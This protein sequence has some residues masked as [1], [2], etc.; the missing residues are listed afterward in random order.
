[1]QPS[2][3]PIATSLNLP[4]HQKCTACSLAKWRK[5]VAPGRGRSDSPLMFVAEAPGAEEDEEGAPLIGPAGRLLRSLVDAMPSMRAD[6][7]FYTN[8]AHCRPPQNDVRYFEETGGLCPK[9]WLTAEMKAIKPKVIVAMGR[10]A[11]AFFRPA[12]QNMPMK[13]HS[14]KDSWDE[15][16]KCWIV[17]MYHPAAALHAGVERGSQEGNQIL[18]SMTISLQRAMYYLVGNGYLGATVDGGDELFKIIEGA[19]SEA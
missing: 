18:V 6:D 15:A 11:C 9:I 10:T 7:Y 12:E 3:V 5:K 19:E 13:W 4:N 1:M 2:L 16:R 8:V 17:G 14:A